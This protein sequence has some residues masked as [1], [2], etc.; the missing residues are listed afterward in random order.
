M[1]CRVVNLPVLRFNFEI[2]LS[3]TM[4][5]LRYD[6]RESGSLYSYPWVRSPT[7]IRNFCT[8]V[9]PLTIAVRPYHKHFGSPSFSLEVIFN[10]LRRL[11]NSCLHWGI[12]K[13]IWI[14]RM[15]AFVVWWE[16]MLHKM[17]RDRCDGKSRIILRIVEL[18]VLDELISSVALVQTISCC[19]AK[20]ERVRTVSYWPPDKMPVMDLAIE[21]FSA[22][23]S[24]RMSEAILRSARTGCFRE[25]RRVVHHRMVMGVK[26]ESN[27]LHNG[28][29]ALF[30][31][32]LYCQWL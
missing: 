1:L 23:H 22:T 25:K 4:D 9:F 13:R 8:D 19:N 7:N 5:S 10:C 18:K 30:T 15:P 24:T 3:Q 31:R 21:G 12:E 27:I 2:Q 32:C 29:S 16:V 20:P 26:K 14:T 11:C 28:G 17:P 6:R